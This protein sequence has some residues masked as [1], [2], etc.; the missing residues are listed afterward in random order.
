[1]NL[2]EIAKTSE[3]P[4][5]TMKPFSA[6]G[7]EIMVVNYNSSYY[8]LNKKCTHKGGNLSMGTLDG[9]VVTCPV[10]GAKF[11]ITTGKNISGPKIG[12]MKLKTG[13]LEV[14]EVKVEGDSIKINI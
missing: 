2:T 6:G 13:D 8:A 14:Y 3:V 5:G 1:M 12:I 11:D 7:K 10:H 9:K 4:E